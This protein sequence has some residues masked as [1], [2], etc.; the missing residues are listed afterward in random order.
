M[1]IKRVL[2]SR[3][4][5]TI[6]LFNYAYSDNYALEGNRCGFLNLTLE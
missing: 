5:I 6:A 4:F 3:R 1:L 2:L